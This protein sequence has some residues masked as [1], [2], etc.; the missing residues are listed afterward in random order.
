ME[1]TLASGHTIRI[2]EH[3]AYLLERYCW[4][5]YRLGGKLRVVALV[6]TEPGQSRTMLQLA[7]L[8]LRAPPRR[9]IRHRNGDT[10]DLTRANL[11]FGRS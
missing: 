8:I 1:A 4:R 7:R 5:A 10:L 2:D 6:Q 9:P 3:D 11:K